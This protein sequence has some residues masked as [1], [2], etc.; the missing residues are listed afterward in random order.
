MLNID[1]VGRNESSTKETAAE[2]EGSI[3][4][5]GARQGGNRLHEVI[6]DAN[7]HIGFRFE[8]DEESIFNRS[9]QFNFYRQG[10]GVAFLFGGFHPD[11]H[12][13]TDVA[14]RLNFRKIQSSARLY[15]LTI[16][17]ADQQGPF[18]IQVEQST[19]LN[20]NGNSA[21]SGVP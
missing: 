20:T 6:M 18:P 14:H 16:F 17:K 5:I 2:N 3:H 15:Y 4:L 11:Y 10:I 9:D 1:M 19:N 21:G 13:R 8:L 12:Q 7:R